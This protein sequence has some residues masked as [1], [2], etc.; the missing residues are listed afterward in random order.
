MILKGTKVILRPVR[1]S[2]AQAFVKWFN[3]KEVNKFLL[4]RHLDLKFEKKYISD[5]IKGKI[6][7]DGIFFCIETRDGVHIG[8]TSIEIKNQRNRCGGFGIII[9]DKNYWNAGYGS[10]A[11]R[12][13]L[14]YGFKKLKLHRIELDVYSYNPRAIKV[15]KR[16]G[17]KKEGVKK[18]H[19]Y[20]NGKFYDT[21][22]MAMLESDWKNQN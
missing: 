7:K 8:S 1:L 6:K 22:I 11:A 3:D 13:I 17:F 20:W 4:I 9:G 12:L 5:R 10:E 18:E 2:D 15:Y 16:L 19:N 21:I 14:D